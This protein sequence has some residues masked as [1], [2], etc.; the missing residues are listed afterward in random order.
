MGHISFCIPH[1][2][3]QIPPLQQKRF[4]MH[5]LWQ[6]TYSFFSAP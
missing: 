3:K 5:D 1:G 2:R 6:Q 4:F